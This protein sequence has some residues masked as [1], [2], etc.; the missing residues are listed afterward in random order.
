MTGLMRSTRYYAYIAAVAVTVTAA[1][2]A[3]QTF[4]QPAP[5]ATESRSPAAVGGVPVSPS[6]AGLFQSTFSDFRRLPS[7]GT[8]TILTIGAVAAIAGH[9]ADRSVTTTFS[10]S[11]DLRGVLGAGQTLGSMQ[12]QLGGAFA[13]YAIGRALGR[14]KVT[15]IGADLVRADLVAQTLTSAVKLS[16]RRTRPDGTAFSFPSGHTAVSF[17]T[18]TVLQRHLGWKAGV[19]AYAV[20]SYVAAS[21]IQDKRHFLSD[22]AFGAAIGIVSGRTVTFG[23]GEHRVT[24]SPAATPA[25]GG[26][27]LTW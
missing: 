12:F 24:M 11:K 8:A 9:N 19:P 1:P 14:G 7:K 5:P 3:S 23:R 13:T 20:A 21:R 27:S 2:A 15:A 17:A 16:V 4:L 6:F 18:A 26:V 25:G 22:V 10:G